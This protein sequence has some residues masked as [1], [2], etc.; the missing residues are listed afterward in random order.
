MT[1]VLA[2]DQGTSGTKAVVVS[3]D[4]AILGLAEQP[5]RPDYSAGGAVEQDPRLLLAS[6]LDA[7]RAALAEARTGVDIVTI[8]N[9]GET[10]LAWDP[11]S[12]APLT[13]LIVWQD[14]RAESICAE[15][16]E[17]RDDIA[18]R[19]GLVVDPYFSAPK[20]TWIRRNLTTE[21]V[22]TTSDSWLLHQ[23]TGEFV[24]DVSTASRSLVTDLDTTT[25]DSELLDLFGLAD[26]ALPTILPS[27]A[28]AGSTSLFGGEVAVGGLV[29]D[30]QAALLAES[31]LLP[32]EA[33]CTFGTGA[34]LLT[35]AGGGAQRSTS[36]LAASVAWSVGGQP[37]YC[38][39]G[40]VYTAASAIRWLENLGFIGHAADLDRV[41][42]PDSEGVFSV[43]AFAG[44]GAP[45]WRSDARASIAGMSLSTGV[46]HIVRSVLEGIAAQ[47]AELGRLV[48]ADI[49]TPLTRLRVDGG[50]T[51]SQVLMQAVA[52]L[53]QIEVD[54]YPSQHATPLGAAALARIAHA[55][56]L[57]LEAAVIGWQPVTVY[58]PR[59]SADRAAEFMA[60]WRAVADST[61]STPT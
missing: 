17:H 24:T 57:S 52:D 12:G 51:R 29:V 53:M 56:G 46:G 23:L 2:I 4:G 47:V 15:L 21:G 34:F 60:Q 8:A 10:V 61:F 27:D 50:L 49:G 14:R 20:Q 36:G 59:W 9:Q 16:V 30:Q 39:D 44:L 33:K 28:I 25:W 1:T 22:V 7:G 6:V 5:L 42:A 45:W 18:A 11:D 3:P 40:Q 19:T 35:N 37:T 54:V 13:N 41:A 26:E 58:I 48:A 32:G 55:P 43:P 31:C 38:F